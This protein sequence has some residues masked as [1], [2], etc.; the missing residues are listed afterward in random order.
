MYTVTRY[1]ICL[2]F[3]VHQNCWQDVGLQY[4]WIRMKVSMVILRKKN[5]RGIMQFLAASKI[6][7]KACHFESWV[8]TMVV[9]RQLWGLNVFRIA[10]FIHGFILG[11]SMKSMFV[12]PV[13][14]SYDYEIRSNSSHQILTGCVTKLKK[15]ATTNQQ[16]KYF[17]I[18]SG[19]K[20]TYIS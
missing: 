15:T 1:S 20:R 12:S 6:K 16:F 13:S 11:L 10:G 17:F 19:S 14:T 7:I 4:L 5:E 3:I 9:E 2:C 18:I 8:E